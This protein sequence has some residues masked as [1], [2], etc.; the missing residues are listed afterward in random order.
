PAISLF[1]GYDQIN[2][3]GDIDIV[4]RAGT[5][6]HIYT[7]GNVVFPSWMAT[8]DSHKNQGDTY[9][10]SPVGACAWRHIAGG[11]CQFQLWRS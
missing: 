7:G 9:E 6:A 11:M 10:L 2:N 3:W 4:Q 1:P 8:R 5:I